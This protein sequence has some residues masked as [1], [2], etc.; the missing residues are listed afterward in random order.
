[1]NT[2]KR[3]AI[4]LGIILSAAAGLT[5][6]IGFVAFVALQMA[7]VKG[8][9]WSAVGWMLILLGCS[10]ASLIALDNLEGKS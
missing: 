10:A 6:G 1:M 2:I 7:G 3:Y 9:S 5:A 8:T 4:A